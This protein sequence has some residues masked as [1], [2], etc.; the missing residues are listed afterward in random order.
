MTPSK[1]V[2]TTAGYALFQ[3]TNFSIYTY[4]PFQIDKQFT[5]SKWT[6]SPDQIFPQYEETAIVGIAGNTN[7]FYFIGLSNLSLPSN[8]IRMKKYDPVQG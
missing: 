4:S 6:L 8:S 7:F 2:G 3:D 1:I 5:T